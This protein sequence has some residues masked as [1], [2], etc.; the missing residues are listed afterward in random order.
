MRTY[1]YLILNITFVSQ[2]SPFPLFNIRNIRLFWPQ[3]TNIMF[4]LNQPKWSQVT[5]LMMELYWLPVASRAIIKFKS[6][7]L[8]EQER[9]PNLCQNPL[10]RA[11]ALLTA[12]LILLLSLLSSSLL[13]SCL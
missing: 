9:P 13:L 3:H 10:P 2:L 1:F 8:S 4:G 7:M 6:L 5:P 12:F 11:P